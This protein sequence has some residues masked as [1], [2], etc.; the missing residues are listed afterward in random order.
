M[1]TTV[2]PGEL[3]AMLH[4][5][6]ELALIDVREQGVFAKAH[7]LFAVCIPLSHMELLVGALVPRRATRIVLCGDGGAA[8]PLID[9]ATRVL[10]QMGYS[11]L[12]SL[13][14]GIQSWRE[15]GYEI[16]SG[17]NVPS[18]AFGEFVEHTY[19]TPHLS[20]DALKRKIDAGEN[21]IV[22]DSRPMEEYRRMNIPTGIDTPGAELVYRVFDL[23]PDPDTLVVVNCAGRTRSIIGAQSLINAGIPNKV[24][25]LKDGT[26]GWH[27][28]GHELEHGQQRRAGP[29]SPG[30]LAKAKQAAQGVA[31]KFAV[32]E[33]DADT[34]NAWHSEAGE[35]TTYLLDVRTREEFEAG[36]LPGSRHARRA[37]LRPP[38]R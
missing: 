35:R 33:I 7:L 13:D 8:D 21:V 31:E 20:A 15:A 2:T 22:L 9:R 27:L 28:A 17:I 25:A 10:A 32:R 18:K 14:G 29:P 26:M 6:G 23:A 16:F 1:G 5:G 11:D 4:D 3:K 12:S 36:H 19:A 38:G 30:G 37:G 34:L 24:M